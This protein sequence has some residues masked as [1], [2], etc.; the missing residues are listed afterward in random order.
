MKSLI[1]DNLV[2]IFN[3]SVFTIVVNLTLIGF[4]RVCLVDRDGLA[5]SVADRTIY[6]A[7]GQLVELG[8]APKMARKAE[9]IKLDK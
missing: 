1:C 2:V 5:R 9:K 8:V 7:V 6:R 3:L 4:S